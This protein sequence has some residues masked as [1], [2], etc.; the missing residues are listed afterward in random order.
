MADKQTTTDEQTAKA[1]EQTPTAEEQTQDPKSDNGK[2]EA[3]QSTASIS[4]TPDGRWQSTLSVSFQVTSTWEPADG[5]GGAPTSNQSSEG[6]TGSGDDTKT[7]IG[8]VPKEGGDDC[9]PD[10]GIKAGLGAETGPGA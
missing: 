2:A 9:Q 8:A 1:E 7:G 4:R 10:K 6:G 3:P 5:K